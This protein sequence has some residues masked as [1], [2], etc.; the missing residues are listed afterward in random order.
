MNTLRASTRPATPDRLRNRRPAILALALLAMPIGFLMLFTIGEV[1]A[2]DASGAVHAITALPLVIL[3]IAAFRWP[4][5]AGAILLVVGGAI[6]IAYLLPAEGRT[7]PI[8]T[9]VIVESILLVPV[10]AG[11]ILVV[12]SRSSRRDPGRD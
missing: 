9:V 2:G 6:A 11:L 4:L 7:L 12:G 8:E 10:L 1:A 5:P 3:A